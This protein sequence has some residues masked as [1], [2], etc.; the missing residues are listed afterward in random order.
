MRTFTL[1]TLFICALAAATAG[2]L[3]AQA[4]TTPKPQGRSSTIGPPAT[5]NLAVLAAK[6]AERDA[7]ARGLRPTPAAMDTR[8]QLS[9]AELSRPFDAP[10]VPAVQVRRS[11]KPAELSTSVPF[12][13]EALEATL[14][15]ERAK[16]A[17]PPLAP[18]SDSLAQSRLHSARAP[19]APAGNA[20]TPSVPLNDAQRAK[21]ERARAAAPSGAVPPGP[22]GPR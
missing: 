2:A 13:G 12:E 16:R 8:A 20:V 7:L 21:L 17:A 11:D 18:R 14:E 1:A 9:P 4:P 10:A 15:R 5:P 3:S 19:G 6:L 22:Q